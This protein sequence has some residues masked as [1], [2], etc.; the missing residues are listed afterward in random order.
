MASLGGFGGLP[1]ELGGKPGPE[2]RA[3]NVLQ[4]AVGVGGSAEDTLDVTTLDGLWRA[5]RAEGLAAIDAVDEAAHWQAFPTTVTDL[6]PTYEKILGLTPQV[7]LSENERR[8]A[9]VNKMTARLGANYPDLLTQ[10]TE[11]DP[12]CS[13]LYEGFATA[14]VTYE[15]KFY[16]V[17]DNFGV[18]TGDWP[19][20]RFNT[21]FP[22]YS[23]K[24]IVT[25]LFNIGAT[26]PAGANA[27][28]L[29]ALNSMLD[30][31]LP[32]WNAF[33]VATQSG[34]TLDT[35]LLDVTAFGA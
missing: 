1:Y 31:V 2:E 34:F 15:G 12:R 13:F 11:I 14:S 20:G 22:N 21:D 7:S 8:Q 3:Y 29:G 18:F 32:A 16:G 4:Q 30:D 28:A 35:S 27:A 9:I 10:A 23:S 19:G 6:I 24:F 26:V 25:V 33:Y 17:V 5:A